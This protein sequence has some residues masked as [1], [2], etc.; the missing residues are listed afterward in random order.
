MSLHR[1]NRLLDLLPSGVKDAGVVF[2]GDVLSKFLTFMLTPMLLMLLSPREYRLYGLFITVLAAVNSLTDLGLQSSFIRFYS[3]Y[4]DSDPDRSAAHLR[5]ALRIKIVLTVSFA[6][7]LYVLAEPIAATMLG[8]PELTPALQLLSFGVLGSSMVEFVLAVRQA[9]LKFIPYA[10]IRMLEGAGKTIPIFL[11]LSIGAFSLDLVFDV[12][13]YSSLALAAG[14]LWMMRGSAPRSALPLRS[15]VP[16]LTNFSKWMTL[17]VLCSVFLTRIDIFM[18]QSILRDNPTEVGLYIMANKLGIPLLVMA[19]SVT[20]VLYPKAMALRSV[21]EMRRY[22]RNAALIA[23]IVLTIAIVYLGAVYFATPRFF[24]KYTGALPMFVVFWIS[25]LWSIIGSPFTLLILSL[26]KSKISAILMFA[27]LMFTIVSHYYF[28]H[29]L[30]GIGAAWSLVL[31]I[32]LFGIIALSYVYRN[33]HLIESIDHN[34]TAALQP[35]IS[36]DV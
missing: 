31:S 22:V 23:L 34:E 11:A 19:A 8:A 7:L 9:Q 3:L 28:I 32:F 14:S 26:N 5:L 20:T 24:P 29:W 35:G 16:E 27:Q 21:K 17:A 4:R 33:R 30:G 15:V 2:S 12:Y 1:R 6:V 13:V 36:S 10:W 18:V 25:Q